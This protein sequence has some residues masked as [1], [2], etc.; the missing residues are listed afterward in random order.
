M[1]DIKKEK[2]Y[3][4]GTGKVAPRFLTGFDV[5]RKKVLDEKDMMKPSPTIDF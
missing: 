3:L 2:T 5:R 1:K 4:N